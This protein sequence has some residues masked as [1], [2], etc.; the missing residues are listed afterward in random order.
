MNWLFFG[1]LAMLS[2]GFYNFFVRL[3]AGKIS[4]AL[5]AV[6]LAVSS[7]IVA[8]SFFLFLKLNGTQTTITTPGI[9]WAIGAGVFAGLAEVLYFFMFAK[10]TNISIGLPLVVGG[11]ILVGAVLGILVLHEKL[12]FI[13]L[14]GG[15]LTVLGIVLLVR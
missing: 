4:P 5:G 15:V 9:W 1:I 7:A 8:T 3:S 12:S 13:K 6:I 11:T 10:G 2:Y 14:A